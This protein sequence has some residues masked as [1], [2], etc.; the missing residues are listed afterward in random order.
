METGLFNLLCAFCR[1]HFNEHS[2]WAGGVFDTKR[3]RNTKSLASSA[4]QGCHFCRLIDH[5]RSEFLDDEDVT[6]ELRHSPHAT[7]LLEF[8]FRPIAEDG[9]PRKERFRCIDLIRLKS[10]P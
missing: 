9:I 7:R 3:V 10:T 5:M 8:R 2:P 4:A 1:D 6:F